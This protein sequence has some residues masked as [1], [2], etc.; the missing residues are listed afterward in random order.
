MSARDPNRT[1]AALAD[2]TRRAVVDV[3]AEGRL[4]A[5]ELADRVSVSPAL[6]TRHLRTL[7]EAGVVRAELDP[8]DHRR[9]VYQLV[10]QP[11]TEMRDWADGV[12]A[13]WERQLEA[14]AEHAESE[15]SSKRSAAKASGAASGRR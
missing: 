14:F 1:F 13:F 3:L 4:S 15:K 9:H 10:S 12:T 5:G 7:R 6:L 2:P 11:L 8:G